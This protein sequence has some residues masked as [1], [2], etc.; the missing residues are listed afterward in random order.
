MG[1]AG[2]AR[3][4]LIVNARR[5]SEDR[6]GLLVAMLTILEDTVTRRCGLGDEGDKRVG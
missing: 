6:M 3:A 4:L 5:S 1:G 2:A